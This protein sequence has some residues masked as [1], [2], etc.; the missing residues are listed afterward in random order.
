MPLTSCIYLKTCWQGCLG[1][2]VSRLLACQYQKSLSTGI[3]LRQLRRYYDTAR[4]I[5]KC[6]FLALNFGGDI[7]Y[8]S[9]VILIK[10]P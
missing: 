7:A 2:E 9:D 5:L 3:W 4:D 8:S 1:N 6:P 10:N